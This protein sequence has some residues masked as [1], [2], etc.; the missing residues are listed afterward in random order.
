L[1]VQL[2][3]TNPIQ[4]REIWTERGINDALKNMSIAFRDSE[5]PKVVLKQA[6][7]IA[8][9]IH[10]MVIICIQFSIIDMLTST[11]KCIH[12]LCI[13]QNTSSLKFDLIV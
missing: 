11:R 12:F 7:I 8:S 5:E 3:V 13:Y 4:Y 2:Q 9:I 6:E 10:T 1:C